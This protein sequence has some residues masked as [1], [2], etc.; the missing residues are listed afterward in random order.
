MSEDYEVLKLHDLPQRHNPRPKIYGLNPGGHADGWVEFD[1]LDGMY[2]YCIAYDGAGNELGVCHLGGW[3]A[4]GF[5]KDGYRRLG[6]I[7]G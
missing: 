6:D 7:N 4:L 2:S 5:H 3:T 1:H